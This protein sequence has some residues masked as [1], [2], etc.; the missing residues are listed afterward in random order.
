MLSQLQALLAAA[1]A[2]RGFAVVCVWF[3]SVVCV[4]ILSCCFVGSCMY[5][6]NDGTKNMMGFSLWTCDSDLMMAFTSVVMVPVPH[7]CRSRPR[8]SV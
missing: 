8:F 5:Q 2:C 3:G 4:V 6:Q 7:S 1:N